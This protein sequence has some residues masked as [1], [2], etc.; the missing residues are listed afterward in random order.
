MQN[1][2]RKHRRL[3]FFFIL[4]FIGIP[5]VFMFGTPSSRPSNA[6]VESSVLAQ[7]GGVPIREAEFRRALDNA[8]ASRSRQGGERPSYSDLD[9][10][11]TAQTVLEQLVDGALL[12][13]R[14]SQRNFSVDKRV[15][16]Q[17]MQKWEMFQDENGVF[18]HEMWN[19][20][21]GSVDRW[22]EIYAEL[23][24]GM[25]RQM[26][27]ST[28]AAPARRMTAA[29][30][31][32]ELKA[33]H[34]T[35]RIK[36][37][38]IEPK[39]EV[40]PEDARK[41]YDD[42]PEA[43]R[44]PEQHKAEYISYPLEPSVPEEAS[45]LV[46]RLRSDEDFHELA[47]EFSTLKEAGDIDLGWLPAEESKAPYMEALF[48]LE[49]G[50]VSEPVAGPMGFYIFKNA[51]ER[52]NP[53]NEE[54]E[55]HGL[56]IVLAA[57]LTPEEIARREQALGAVALKIQEGTDPATAAEEAGLSLQQTDFFDRMATE[58]S[59]L[60][61]NDLFA[62]RS[63]VIAQKDNPWQ[64][65]KGQDNLF[66][67]RII[68]SREGAIPE[69]ADVEEQAKDNFIAETKRSEA[70]LDEIA[71]YGKKIK[72]RVKSIGEIAEKFTELD[73]ESGETEEAFTRKD[74]LFQQKIYVQTTEIYEAFKDALPGDIAG[75]VNGFFGDAWFFELIEKTEPAE[76]ALEGLADELQAIEQRLAMS[77]EM[78][79]MTDYVKDLKERMLASV[80][81]QQNNDVLDRVLGRGKYAMEEEEDTTPE[82]AT[83]EV[84][85]E[86]AEASEE[87]ET[88]EGSESV[89]S[90]EEISVE[91]LEADESG[92][93]GADDALVE[94]ESN[95]E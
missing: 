40:A 62:F 48:A 7:V 34:T 87:V 23:E 2:M 21:V 55:V 70:Y 76:E 90:T 4:I 27:L 13:L 71:D 43:Y 69:F 1:W 95:D 66:I 3:I 15:L 6:P 37:A 78:A 84:V 82:E 10:D 30:A 63:H 88:V 59:P 14:S 39:I 77:A 75:P 44:L 18:N 80:P 57:M 22:D 45:E 86:A 51:E 68:E 42:N 56:Q 29:K 72:D 64:V 67:T 85:E 41:H 36:Y 58:I 79:I 35:L 24:E 92:D 89:E 38:K 93:V 60:T 49:A 25:G 17:Q 19:E 83:A 46:A 5:F 28:I 54:R 65:I 94:E 74:M 33:D 61:I 91:V 20:W 47:A 9:K 16:E 12:R 73:V 81:Y 52:V 11:G 50:A 53:D 26:F 31:E 32:E 8:A